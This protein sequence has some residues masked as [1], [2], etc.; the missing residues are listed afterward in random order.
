MTTLD[1]LKIKTI[2]NPVTPLDEQRRIVAYLNNVQAR[3][4]SHKGMI[5][6]REVQSATG[7]NCPRCYRPC[8]IGNFPVSDISFLGED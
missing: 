7:R 5:S 2:E 8:W 3:L 1:L 6:L 4:A